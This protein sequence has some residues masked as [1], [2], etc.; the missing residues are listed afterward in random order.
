MH[1]NTII[2]LIIAVLQVAAEYRKVIGNYGLLSWT[3][4]KPK[5]DEFKYQ[6][7]IE[8]T[9]HDLKGIAYVLTKSKDFDIF[10]HLQVEFK[11][12]PSYS[13]NSSDVYTGLGKADVKGGTQNNI[14]YVDKLD[15]FCFACYS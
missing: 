13:D 9:R 4:S 11:T 10:A 2:L 5:L 14:V 6:P 8:I 3:T 1:I 7:Y 12:R 15:F